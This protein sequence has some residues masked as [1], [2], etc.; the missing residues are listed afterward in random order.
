MG[1]WSMIGQLNTTGEGTAVVKECAPA[2]KADAFSMLC[3]VR[4]G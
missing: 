4:E 2:R 3:R 1:G